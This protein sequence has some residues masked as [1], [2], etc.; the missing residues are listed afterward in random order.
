MRFYHYSNIK[1]EGSLSR[2]LFEN[3]RQ[4]LYVWVDGEQWVQK[5][6]YQPQEDQVIEASAEGIHS[7]TVNQKNR[8][9]I[10][11]PEDVLNQGFGCALEGIA[12]PNPET[13]CVECSHFQGPLNQI[14][15][16]VHQK[17]WQNIQ[18][19]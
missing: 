8:R 4:T 7:F 18:L 3:S 2:Y 14:V 11:E 10:S 17:N 19:V 12:C 13:L 1:K 5:I 6:H 16:M 9:E 15:Q